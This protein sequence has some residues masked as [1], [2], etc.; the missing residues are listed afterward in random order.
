MENEDE[1]KHNIND[2]ASTSTTCDNTNV[3]TSAQNEAQNRY[4]VEVCTNK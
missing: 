4:V 2:E 3:H 1:Q